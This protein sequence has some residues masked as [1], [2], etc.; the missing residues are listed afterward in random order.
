MMVRMNTA[1]AERA[2]LVHGM[3]GEFARVTADDVSHPY[4]ERVSTFLEQVRT[5][6]GMDVAF[7]S[8]FTDERRVFEVVTVAA[9]SP[10]ALA[11]GLSDP[12]M[13]TYCK[14]IVDGRLPCVIRNAPAS[15][16]AEL[17]SITA[18]LQIG[19]YLSAPVLLGNGQV[20][21]TLCCISHQPREDLQQ[22]DAQA[23]RALA[24]AIAFGIEQ[25]ARGALR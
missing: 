15:V 24:D 17:Q 25:R 22:A 6:L 5:V 18:R 13:E 7:V 12:L 1:P 23:L 16:D 3:A 19:A 4:W 20:F 9:D 10:S 21:G 14:R 2:E 11:C 8:R